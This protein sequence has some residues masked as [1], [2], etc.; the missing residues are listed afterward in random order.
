VKSVNLISMVSF[1]LGLIISPVGSLCQY[2][3]ARR[4]TKSWTGKIITYSNS[5][6]LSEPNTIAPLV[7]PAE[8]QS[9]GTGHGAHCVLRLNAEQTS[10]LDPE[11]TTTISS[12]DQFFVSRTENYPD[13]SDDVK[14][15]VLYLN[16]VSGGNGYILSCLA[17]KGTILNALHS[18]APGQL[19]DEFLNNLFT[20][21]LT[22][23]QVQAQ[24]QA[25]TKA[26]TNRNSSS[27]PK[28]QG[29]Y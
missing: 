8:G 7:I 21:Q 18:Q 9:F 17:G 12:F 24:L 16:P 11:G 25:Q 4:A 26:Q 14:R 10:S 1:F 20:D 22:P 3:E 28:N 19:T 5:G 27:T 6:S 23:E 2:R 15:K 13:I 29:S